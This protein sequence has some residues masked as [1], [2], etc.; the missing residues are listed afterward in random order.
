[1][2][3]NEESSRRMQTIGN[4]QRHPQQ[5]VDNRPMPRSA[6]VVFWGWLIGC[7]MGLSLAKQYEGTA[8][9][10]S[11]FGRRTVVRHC[12]EATENHHARHGPLRD[13]TEGNSRQC[14]FF[15]SHDHR[16]SL[17][18]LEQSARRYRCDSQ[19]NALT[20][21]GDRPSAAFCAPEEELV[22]GITTT[23]GPN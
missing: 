19:E 8:K 15:V 21:Q 2:Y 3:M 17:L 16:V 9:A 20:T 10:C 14:A 5:I 18:Y 22:S 12:G 4:T 13:A 6:L 11:A 7:R 23:R 1:M